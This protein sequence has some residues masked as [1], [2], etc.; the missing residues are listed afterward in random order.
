MNDIEI[1][2]RDP[3]PTAIKGW[4]GNRFDEVKLTPF[5]SGKGYTGAA[6]KNGH[7]IPV[8]L[9]LNAAGKYASLLFESD[10]TPWADDL[11]CAREAWQA[12]GKETRCATGE[13]QENAEEEDDLWWRINEDGET[14]V[15]WQV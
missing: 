7:S 1:Y 9:F 10:E 5:P 14:Q 12:L 8:K 6:E 11:S 15:R 4:L 3:D 2:I 13:W